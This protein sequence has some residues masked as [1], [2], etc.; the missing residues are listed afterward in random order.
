MWAPCPIAAFPAHWRSP[1][2]WPP[3]SLCIRANL[4]SRFFPH[5]DPARNSRFVIVFFMAL[6]S[7]ARA[8]GRSAQ[9]GRLT[10]SRSAARRTARRVAAQTSARDATGTSALSVAPFITRRSARSSGA[11]ALKKV[12]TWYAVRMELRAEDARGDESRRSSLPRDL[13]ET[14]APTS[15]AASAR[16]RA[17]ARRRRAP[18]GAVLRPRRL[19]QSAWRRRA[20]ADWCGARARTMAGSP[21]SLLRAGGGTRAPGAK[22]GAAPAIGGAEK[23]ARTDK[24]RDKNSKGVLIFTMTRPSDSAISSEVELARVSIWAQG[25]KCSSRRCRYIVSYY[26][27]YYTRKTA[28]AKLC[29]I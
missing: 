12:A 19:R 7:R 10:A 24:S 28:A 26:C 21:E 13:F 27:C 18:R 15:W 14:T 22:A 1:R 17:A 6:A 25:R 4:Q 29:H 3:T 16:T 2:K 8:P 9:V 20:Q 5:L 11:R 23:C